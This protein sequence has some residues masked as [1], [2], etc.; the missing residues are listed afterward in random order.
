MLVFR[1]SISTTALKFISSDFKIKLILSKIDSQVPIT[2]LGA[3]LMDKS[4]RRPLIMVDNV[5]AFISR[6]CESY[7]GCRVVF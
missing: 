7:I 6:T 3:I 4:G 5:V 1:Y 2:L